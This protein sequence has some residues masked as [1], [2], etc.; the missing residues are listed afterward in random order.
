MKH[1]LQELVTNCGFF[2]LP[3]HSSGEAKT[4]HKNLQ[5]AGVTKLGICP[6]D[7]RFV[8]ITL[9][10]R[11]NIVPDEEAMAVVNDSGIAQAHIVPGLLNPK[12]C[13]LIQP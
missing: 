1:Y 10:D 4:A 2:H 7:A 13:Q 5:D 3:A 9:P 12:D 11:W 8:H 6:K